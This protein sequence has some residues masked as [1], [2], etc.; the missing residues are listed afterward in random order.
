MQKTT[1]RL[2][3]LILV[4]LV[5]LGPLI[6]PAW[7][8]NENIQ[9]YGNCHVTTSVDEFTDERRVFLLC[10][11]EKPHLGMVLDEKMGLCIFLASNWQ[12]HVGTEIPIRIRVDKGTLIQ[13][14]AHYLPASHSALVCEPSLVHQLL[15]DLARGQKVAIEIGNERGTIKLTGS[16]RAVADFR[17]RAGLPQQT[18]EIPTH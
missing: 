5:L 3:S 1:V 13:R 10:G 8:A 16:Q 6:Q 7:S 14:S 17:H 15:H 18:L 4:R 11:R 2:L 12:A 9:R